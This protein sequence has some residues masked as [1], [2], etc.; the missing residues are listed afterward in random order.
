MGLDFYR[1]GRGPRQELWSLMSKTSRHES[2]SSAPPPGL[3]VVRDLQL[4][5]KAW[6]GLGSCKDTSEPE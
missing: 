1:L 6:R 4:S 5:H 3:W 2:A